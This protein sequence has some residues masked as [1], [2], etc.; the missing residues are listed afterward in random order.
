MILSK[1]CIEGT[2]EERENFFLAKAFP[3]DT[4]DFSSKLWLDW[5]KLT[6]LNSWIN[7]PKHK[8]YKYLVEL[9]KNRMIDK[10]ILNYVMISELS[11]KDFDKMMQGFTGD[12][13]ANTLGIA[14]QFENIADNRPK[15]RLFVIFIRDIEDRISRQS[16]IWFR[17]FGG[18]KDYYH[19]D[20]EI[21]I[22]GLLFHELVHAEQ[23]IIRNLRDP[24]A[25][26]NGDYSY[27]NYLE[28][29]A[30]A[31]EWEY[32]DKL[33]GYPYYLEKWGAKTYEGAAKKYLDYL[34]N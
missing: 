25:R 12:K 9:V 7:D 3:D 4:D 29:E 34:I 32:M 27:K 18:K 13:S 2:I 33:A 26:G 20:P 17:L 11:D 30:Y 21:V 1:Y 19:L 31:R 23:R 10:K 24:P 6:I 14:T 5:F 28:I 16:S 8:H 22:K 15:E